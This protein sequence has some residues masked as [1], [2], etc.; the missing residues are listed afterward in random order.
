MVPPPGGGGGEGT[1]TCSKTACFRSSV[2]PTY[3]SA[4]STSTTP[5]S[6]N[7][8]AHEKLRAK[9]YLEVQAWTLEQ[10]PMGKRIDYCA[11]HLAP[12]GVSICATRYLLWTVNQCRRPCAVAEWSGADADK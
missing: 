6:T 10:K 3:T 5:Q 2:M 11:L 4:L 12:S 8:I 9:Q 7:N 1:N